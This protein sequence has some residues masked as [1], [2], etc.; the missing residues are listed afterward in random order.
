[1]ILNLEKNYPGILIKSLTHFHEIKS[2]RNC[3][4]ERGK[5]KKISWEEALKKVY[6]KNTYIGV[7]KENEDIAKLMQKKGLEQEIFDIA[8]GLREKANTRNVPEHILGKEIK[9][10]TILETIS[11]IK[12]KTQKE[13][14]K[15]Q[16]QLEEVYDKQFTYE[17]LSKNDPHNSIIGLFCG[18]C[19]TITNDAYGRDITVASII[20]P[21]VQNLV[22]RDQNGEIVSKGT[23]Y[24]NRKKGYGVINEFDI[25][26]QYKRNEYLPGKYKDDSNSK[27]E[28]ERENIF[29]AFQR[30]IMAFVEEYDKQN[31]NRPL[32][33]INVGMGYNRL[34]K[35]VEKFKKATSNLE[36]PIEYNFQDAIEEEQRIL[37]KREERQIEN[38]GKER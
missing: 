11:K 28:K 22:V 31:I 7:T 15:G 4:D 24:L 32:K 14:I 17:W 1:M 35:Q 33:Q 12:D 29:K 34:K 10:E 38:G 18:C 8:V 36:I 16:Q 2:A 25:N 13:L 3:L 19:A 23:M 6:E 5:P 20:S 37:Y 30:G 21:D 26:P 9:E 27:N